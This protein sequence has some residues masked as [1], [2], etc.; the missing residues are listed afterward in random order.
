MWTELDLFKECARSA[1]QQVLDQHVHAA[2]WSAINA[3]LVQQFAS[4]RGAGIAAFGRL[5]WQRCAARPSAPEGASPQLRPV[6]IPADSYLR[7][8][9]LHHASSATRAITVQLEELAPCEEYDGLRVAL[10]FSR[11]LTRAVVEGCTRRLLAALGEAVR[12]GRQVAVDMGVG[13]LTGRDRALGFEFLPSYLAAHRTVAGSSRPGAWASAALGARRTARQQQHQQQKVQVQ[14]PQT[15]REELLAGLAQL[16]AELEEEEAGGD[17]ADEG[18]GDAGGPDQNLGATKVPAAPSRSTSPGPVREQ[19][20]LSAARAQA[21]AV[22]RGRSASPRCAAPAQP[23]KTG[24]AAPDPAPESVAAQPKPRVQQD[25]LELWSPDNSLRS[26][27][28]RRAAGAAAQAQRRTAASGATAG[29]KDASDTAPWLRPRNQCAA[30]QCTAEPAAPQG[31]ALVQSR[32]GQAPEGAMRRVSCD[33]GNEGTSGDIGVED[34]HA[35]RSARKPLFMSPPG[36]KL[37]P[38]AG[39]DRATKSRRDAS[40]QHGQL[41]PGDARTGKSGGADA[42]MLASSADADDC[43]ASQPGRE[44]RPDQTGAFDRSRSPSPGPRPGS[45]GVVVTLAA[46]RSASPGPNMRYGSGP[47]AAD[48]PSVSTAALSKPLDTTCKQAAHEVAGGRVPFAR[49]VGSGKAAVEDQPLCLAKAA[50]AGPASP[51]RMCNDALQQHQQQLAKSYLAHAADDSTVAAVDVAAAATGF[52][53]LQRPAMLG[54]RAGRGAPGHDAGVA[55]SWELELEAELEDVEDLLEGVEQC[56]GSSGTDLLDTQQHK[57]SDDGHGCG[58]SS[59]K[60]GHGFEEAG[61]GGGGGNARRVSRPGGNSS[62]GGCTEEWSSSGMACSSSATS[63]FS[64]GRGGASLA[65]NG[66]SLRAGHGVGGVGVD[67]PPRMAAPVASTS[68][69]IALA[70]C[71][72]ESDGDGVP[73]GKCGSLQ[74]PPQCTQSPTRRCASISASE[75]GDDAAP[76]AAQQGWRS[77]GWRHCGDGSSST[78]TINS[79][80]GL[81]G[82]SLAVREEDLP[83]PAWG[84]RR[85]PPAH[86]QG[87]PWPQQEQRWRQTEDAQEEGNEEEED[88]SDDGDGELPE[89]QRYIKMVQQAAAQ[90]QWQHSSDESEVE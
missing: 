51:P 67:G 52:L 66:S 87:A 72:E 50:A 41:L 15:R 81:R 82:R 88:W 17:Q 9:A 68:Q 27:A 85:P 86:N 47:A 21:L 65:L 69:G 24:P 18:A 79:S 83:G 53:S 43:M 2:V 30:Q 37:P 56:L 10:K 77:P 4:H 48:G 16:Q 74:M 84:S 57:Q 42:T 59:S 34:Q 62:A 12:S 8:H 61:G 46:V 70:T 44:W 31:T 78:G 63:C 19:R 38:A 33:G 71:Q 39:T 49:L 80:R 23:I 36:R 3:W 54:R 75:D 64:F 6:F 73:A 14:T 5:T 55:E 7:T 13:T 29:G 58:G 26:A 90:R 20:P 32:S 60:L 40:A 35:L 1:K 11:S 25:A 45:R 22:L 76:A 89:V 28:G